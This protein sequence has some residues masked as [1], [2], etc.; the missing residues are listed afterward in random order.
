[1]EGLDVHTQNEG[2][3]KDDKMS[4]DKADSYGWTIKKWKAEN[5]TAR[6]GNG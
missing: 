5:S 3:N 2:A 1:M 6:S 4:L